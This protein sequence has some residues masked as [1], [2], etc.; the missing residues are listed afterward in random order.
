MPMEGQVRFVSP[1]NS[2][3]VLQEKDVAVICQTTVV[4]GDQNSNIKKQDKT[5]NPTIKP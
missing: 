1:Q 2:A 3:A 5:K 4:N